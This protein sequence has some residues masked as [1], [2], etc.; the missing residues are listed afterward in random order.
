MDYH[1]LHM[2]TVV[3]L[4]K[5]AKDERVRIPAG[6]SKAGIIDLI[7]EQRGRAADAVPETRDQTK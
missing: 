3:E 5:I 1:S 4:R 2:K 6:T 7:L